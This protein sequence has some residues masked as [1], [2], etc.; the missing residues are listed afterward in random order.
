MFPVLFLCMKIPVCATLALF[1]HILICIFIIMQPSIQMTASLNIFLRHL[2]H[3]IIFRVTLQ[4]IY[5]NMYK[6]FSSYLFYRDLFKNN[7]QSFQWQFFPSSDIFLSLFSVWSAST[8]KKK[9]WKIGAKITI[10]TK[11]TYIL[12]PCILKPPKQV[13]IIISHYFWLKEI[14]YIMAN[15]NIAWYVH[16]R[17]QNLSYKC[18]IQLD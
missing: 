18:E 11:H 10:S 17:I 13:N 8:N 4:S 3:G 7:T 15:T 9:S 2:H 16:K 12:F 1:S 14:V 5:N 6:M